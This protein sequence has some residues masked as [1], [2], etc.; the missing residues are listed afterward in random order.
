MCSYEKM[1]WIGAL[2]VITVMTNLQTIRYRASVYLPRYSGGV[3]RNP[4]AGFPPHVYSRVS[5]FGK[6]IF[7]SPTSVASDDIGFKLF[8][9][10]GVLLDS[11]STKVLGIIDCVKRSSVW[12]NRRQ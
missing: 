4:L 1:L 7:P 6:F 8:E 11:H 2:R 12:Q 10:G 5:G 3:H 9:G